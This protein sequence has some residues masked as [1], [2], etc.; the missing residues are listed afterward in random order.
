MS[1]NKGATPPS[2]YFVRSSASHFITSKINIASAILSEVESGF[3]CLRFRLVIL[4]P[5]DI[6]YN[7]T[8]LQLCQV[9]ERKERLKFKL[10]FQLCISLLDFSD[11]SL[12]LSFRH[13]QFFNRFF[14]A[15]GAQH[16]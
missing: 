15:T 7:T 12:Y 11:F 14:S 8:L 5:P 1:V 10:K 6:Y 13:E 9:D 3:F 2:A 16:D 4:L